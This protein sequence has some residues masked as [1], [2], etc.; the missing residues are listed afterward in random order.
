MTEKLSVS[1]A[2]LERP[3]TSDPGG[4]GF[5]QVLSGV[6]LVVRRG[7]V[8]GVVG[9]SGSGKTSL[10]RLMNGLDSPSS[11]RI[12]LDGEDVSR[13]DPIE[14]RRRVGMV[15]QAPALFPGTVGANV[16]YP[17][18]LL[19]V[20]GGERRARGM[21]CLEQVGL[22]PSFWDRTAPELSRGEQQRVSV[23]RALANRPEVVLMDEPTSALDPASVRTMLGLVTRLNEETGT[24]I[25]FVT[26]L[27]EQARAVC[28][29]A[30]IL[31]DGRAVEEGAVGDALS[32]PRTELGAAFVEGRLDPHAARG[33]GGPAR[34]GGA[35]DRGEAPGEAS[36]EGRNGTAGGG[37]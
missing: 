36:G 31:V 23:A 4:S 8:Y 9:P 20:A 32:S 17:L 22:P 12:S 25:V 27:L 10:L 5:R 6:S 24:T 19:G 18:G 1:E 33:D 28:E 30:V 35:A 26:H 15:F 21:A 11:G 7:E 34:E 16:E 37:R 3:D 29:R 13:L 2:S 14:L